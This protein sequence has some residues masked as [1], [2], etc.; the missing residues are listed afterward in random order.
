MSMFLVLKVVDLA[1]ESMFFLYLACVFAVV[2]L[3]F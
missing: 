3:V 1:F 2:Y